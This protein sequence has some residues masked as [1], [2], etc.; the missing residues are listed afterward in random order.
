MSDGSRR[1][2]KRYP[3]AFAL[4]VLLF[5]VW[6]GAHRVFNAVAPQF[7]KFFAY[8]HLQSSI[9][10]VSLNLSYLLIALPVALFLRRFG[11]KLGLVGGL[12]AFSL[13]ALLLYPA[14]IRHETVFYVAAVAITGAGWAFLEVSAN[15]LIVRMGPPD[16]AVRRLNLAQCFY[17][18]GLALTSLFS[19]NLTLPL[20][21]LL[22][23]T[24]VD[25]VVRPYVMVG[26]CVLLLAFVIENAD[27]PKLASERHPRGARAIDEIKALYALPS[28][29]TGVAALAVF[30][31]GLVCLWG[32]TS[33]YAIHTLNTPVFVGGVTFS[34]LTWWLC[35]AGRLVGT[36]LM[37]RIDPLRLL[38]AFAAF[39]TV[40]CLVPAFDESV[41]ALGCMIAASFF[42]SIMFPTIFAVT[43]RD[44]GPLTK[45]GAGILVAASGLGGFVGIMA[46]RTLTGVPGFVH[47]SLMIAG[48]CFT[49]VLLFALSQTVTR[50]ADA[51]AGE[52]AL[53]SHD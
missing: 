41:V 32:S 26:L 5:A 48:S 1:N 44:L 49:V 4:T 50:T 53:P 7:E 15:T 21:N 9:V 40:L 2:H 47:V 33:R 51:P 12:G 3:L 8:D 36:G 29:R 38:A 17:P 16:T 52:P 14:V 19:T 37:S 20:Q 27:F 24:F 42:I 22:P 46:Q 13:G 28:F 30:T 11:Y 34:M 43:V 31:T 23:G 10:F 6:G 35:L 25:D 39:A 45:M 18:A